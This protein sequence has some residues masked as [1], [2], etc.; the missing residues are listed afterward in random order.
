[1]PTQY[2]RGPGPDRNARAPEVIGRRSRRNGLPFPQDPTACQ[3]TVLE[4]HVPLP[5]G[6]Y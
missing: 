4:S 1:M 3:D 6:K 5:E 2:N